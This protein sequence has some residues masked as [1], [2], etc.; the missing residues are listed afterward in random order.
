MMRWSNPSKRLCPLRIISGSKLPSRSR[1]T[2][3]SIDPSGLN[4]R[5][6]VLPLRQ[7]ALA[8][9]S[10]PAAPASSAAS[11]VPPASATVSSSSPVAA[12]RR[13]PCAYPRWLV[14]SPSRTLCSTARLN[15]FI[16]PPGPK[17]ASAVSPYS[18]TRRFATSSVNCS[19]CVL[20]A[21]L[22]YRFCALPHSPPRTQTF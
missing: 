2:V 15:S 16:N 14:I 17:I 4:T 8:F 22:I 6:R 3:I 20:I 10:G 5:L 9:S 13:S 11:V 21:L 1:G 12:F 7:F 18:V 19:R